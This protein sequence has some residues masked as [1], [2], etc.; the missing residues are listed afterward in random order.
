VLGGAGLAGMAAP[1]AGRLAVPLID[2]ASAGV[3]ALL[4][5]APERW[6]APPAPGAA[7]VWTGL[8]HALSQQLR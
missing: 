3:V 7:P 4:D 5:E 6:S 1:L 8:T 2:S